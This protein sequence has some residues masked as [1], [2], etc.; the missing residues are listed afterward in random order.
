MKKLIS[1]ITIIALFVAT[2]TIFSSC[3]SKA[4]AASVD[5]TK[6][7]NITWSY[8]SE[9]KTLKIVGDVNNPV[10]MKAFAKA[11]EL[12]WY[13]VR[14]SAV[15]LEITGVAKISNYA[16]YGMY[17]I[18]E[19]SFGGSVTDIGNCAFA[20]CS[21]L[22]ELTLPET[23]K[24]IGVSAF[25]G[26]AA[27]KSVKLPASIESIGERAFA[28]N[29]ALTSLSID[30]SFLTALPQAEFDAI[31]MGIAKPAITTTGAP[32]SAPEGSTTESDS[33]STEES[34]EAATD[35]TEKSE[36]ETDK[37]TETEAPAPE[38]QNDVTTIIAIVVL[39]LVIVGLVVGGILLTRSNK[40]QAK[41]SRTV[42]KNADSKSNKNT[43][44][45]G[46]KK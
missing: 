43:N 23:V 36:S 4:G 39:A 25:E 46:K 12:P 3:G 8:S 10:E 32:E 38:K 37:S 41:D 6:Y 14:T 2:L 27:L 29:H 30:Q 1:L 33:T 44:S 34:T 15:K 42:R 17:Y 26:C 45:K 11:S 40:N 35:S 13:N 28:Y 22:E 18:K 5:A 16:F 7:D 21:S 20:F 24:S 9:T 19:I 31:F